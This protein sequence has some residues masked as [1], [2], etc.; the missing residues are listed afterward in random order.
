MRNWNLKTNFLLTKKIWDFI[1]K[2]AEKKIGKQN[3]KANRKKI[4]RQIGRQ[5]RKAKENSNMVII[6]NYTHSSQCIH[7]YMILISYLLGIQG[8]FEYW[9]KRDADSSMFH[10]TQVGKNYSYLNNM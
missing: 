4:R 10:Y 1:Y 6:L 7:R 3:R 2:C 5:N 9:F 8:L